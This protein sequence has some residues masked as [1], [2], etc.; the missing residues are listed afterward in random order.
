MVN[1]TTR[2]HWG[3]AVGLHPNQTAHPEDLVERWTTTNKRAF[4][5][6]T[7]NYEDA[8]GEG[9][10]LRHVETF[11]APVRNGAASSA[12][13]GSHRHHRRKLAEEK[14]RKL[15]DHDA[16]TGLP[17]RRLFQERLEQ[18]RTVPGGGV[19]LGPSS[20]ST[21]TTSRASTT[22]WA[23]TPATGS[24]AR[25]RVA[26]SATVAA[27][28]PWPGSVTRVRHHPR[29]SRPA[30][31]CRDRRPEGPG[32]A[33]R[34][35]SDGDRELRST[36]SP[37][38]RL[39]SHARTAD[40]MLKA[41]DLALHSQGGG[42]GRGRSSTPR[43]ARTARPVSAGSIPSRIAQGDQKCRIVTGSGRR[44]GSRQRQPPSPQDR[45]A[46]RSA[47]RRSPRQKQEPL[48]RFP[49]RERRPLCEL[50]EARAQLVL[51]GPAIRRPG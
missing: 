12:S 11:L 51:V 36:A 38:R 41:A 32:R 43:S 40:G 13:S 37:D 4:S 47:A 20:R 42:R 15:A 17:N 1:S 22:R 34:A 33:R 39:S 24:F 8:Y 3:D 30:G 31:G 18:A 5:G 9:E 6:E 26:W 21:S 27:P 2:T 44:S 50:R 10:V 49:D 46:R 48:A 25:W 29:G 14:I 45:P 35:V 7:F 16:L 28:T 23:M 19:G